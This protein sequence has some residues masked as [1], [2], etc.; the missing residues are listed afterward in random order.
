MI[1]ASTTV[2][3]PVAQREDADEQ[4]R[5]VAQRALHDAGRAGTE[6]VGDLLDAAADQRRKRGQREARQR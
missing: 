1:A 3:R 2:I 4:L 5:Q 6:P